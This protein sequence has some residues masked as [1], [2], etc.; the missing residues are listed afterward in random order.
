MVAKQVH[1]LQPVSCSLLDSARGKQKL[2]ALL[3]D[4]SKGKCCSCL[5]ATAKLERPVLMS[6]CQE[7]V[8]RACATRK[9]DERS[10]RSLTPCLFC[11]CRLARLERVTL[12]LTAEF[13]CFPCTCSPR[14]HLMVGL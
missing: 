3:N 5:T 8:C 10:G 6:C 7:I 4:L 12:W 9:L 14:G 2:L 13:L 11:V 1:T